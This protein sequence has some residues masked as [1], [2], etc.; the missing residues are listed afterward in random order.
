MAW[1]ARILVGVLIYLGVSGIVEKSDGA[2]EFLWLAS[3]AMLG[4]ILPLSLF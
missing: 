3:A 4:V 2:A 1:L